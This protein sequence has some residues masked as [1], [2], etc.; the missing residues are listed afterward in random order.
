MA[1]SIA[2]I[3]AELAEYQ[4]QLDELRALLEGEE[5][6]G[7]ASEVKEVIR[8]LEEAVAL[9]KELLE[10]A[11][12][13]EREG[14]PKEERGE[15]RGEGQQG[16]Q[17]N[18]NKAPATTGRTIE[19]AITEAPEVKAPAV[20]GEDVKKQLRER[21]QRSALEG[22]AET[23]WAIGASVRGTKDA[24]SRREG[25]VR[26]VSKAG[27]MIV[28]FL[29]GG[30]EMEF[31]GSDLVYLDNAQRQKDSMQAM[32]E[33]LGGDTE[34]DRGE[35]DGGEKDRGEKDRGE[36]DRGEKDRGEKDR[37]TTTATKTA[38]NTASNTA[39][40]NDNKKRKPPKADK[41]TSSWQNFKAGKKVSK[42]MTG[43]GKATVR[44]ELLSKP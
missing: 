27:K 12:Q 30:D 4:E 38:N 35:K 39:N 23:A 10:A 28:R 9:S 31:D 42:R 32:R 20:L 44:K 3:E 37:P 40:N 34:K 25:V 6:S 33:S 16:Q 18:K 8:D 29:D 5:H 21:Q 41:A 7:D 13:R 2:E 15:E 19:A 17:G 36:K 11:R 14:K 24:G 43:T 22:N 26:G 1:S